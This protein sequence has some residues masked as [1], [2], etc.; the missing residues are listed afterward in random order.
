MAGK[1]SAK[2]KSKDTKSKS[3]KRDDGS[4][5]IARAEKRLAKAL[6]DVHDARAKVQRRERDLAA[7][8][9]RH[10][11]TVPVD[12]SHDDAIPLEAPT[13]P[14]ST[15]GASDDDAEPA[16]TEPVEQPV[17]IDGEEHHE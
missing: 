3:K 2:R 16:E 8:M 7:L 5:E 1:Q 12:N 11:R 14:V 10:G 17:S 13:Q 15:N 9:E 6:A 4:A